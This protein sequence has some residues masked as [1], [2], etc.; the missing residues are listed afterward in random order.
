M[1]WSLNLQTKQT[2]RCFSL[3]FALNLSISVE[4]ESKWKDNGKRKIRK[5]I[6]K[7]RSWINLQSVCIWYFQSI[8]LWWRRERNFYEPKVMECQQS[9]DV[10]CLSRKFVCY[11]LTL[12]EDLSFKAEEE[13]IVRDGK[14]ENVFEEKAAV[15][16]D[17]PQTYLASFS[18]SYLSLF[19]IVLNNVLNSSNEHFSIQLVENVTQNQR[20]RSLWNLL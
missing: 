7:I 14:P 20:A 13:R 1:I 8:L 11:Q 16:L 3:N 18:T 5:I 9:V 19:I 17:K 10:C 4:S 15:D 12:R 6:I 2:I